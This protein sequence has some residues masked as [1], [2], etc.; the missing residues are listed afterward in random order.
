MIHLP[1]QETMP[2]ILCSV[3]QESAKQLATQQSMNKAIPETS[4]RMHT[5]CCK[6]DEEAVTNNAT[7]STK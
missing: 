6:P 3:W 4:G 1:V 7:A 2:F 5:M